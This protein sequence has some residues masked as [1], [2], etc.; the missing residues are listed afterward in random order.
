MCALESHSD[1][2]EAY[3]SEDWKTGA[4]PT[5]VCESV[6]LILGGVYGIRSVLHM[7]VPNEND[8]NEVVRIIDGLVASEK[9]KIPP[10][11]RFRSFFRVY[12]IVGD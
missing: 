7:V 4:L 11:R 5:D 3:W 1:L 10:L 9:I 8:D 6:R 2:H 12:D